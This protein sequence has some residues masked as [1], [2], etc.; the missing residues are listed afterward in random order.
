MSGRRRDRRDDDGW[1]VGGKVAEGFIEGGAWDV[2]LGG[3]EGNCALLGRDLFHLRKLRGVD[4]G[5]ER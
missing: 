1:S 3:A 4:E 2:V 5:A